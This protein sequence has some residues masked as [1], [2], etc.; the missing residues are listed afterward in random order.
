MAT[1]S[2]L[3]IYA[4]DLEK[5]KNGKDSELIEKI[6]KGSRFEIGF[7]IVVYFHSFE[8]FEYKPVRK[9]LDR[10]EIDYVVGTV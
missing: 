9:L 6:L 2:P 4:D 7:Y 10:L 5:H 1:Y 3:L 8:G